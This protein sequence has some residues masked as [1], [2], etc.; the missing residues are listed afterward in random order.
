MPV[1]HKPKFQAQLGSHY[2][3]QSANHLAHVRVLGHYAIRS[4]KLSREMR[5]KPSSDQSWTKSSRPSVCVTSAAARLR[6]KPACAKIA[7]E[8][9]DGTA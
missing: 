3:L 5:E 8:A 7:R 9:L 2:N 4:G 6:S 1:C